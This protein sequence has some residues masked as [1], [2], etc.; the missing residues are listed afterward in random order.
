M[1]VR[2]CPARPGPKLQAACCTAVPPRLLPLHGQ[3]P[4]AH[5]LHL[6]SPPPALCQDELAVRRC[7]AEFRQQHPRYIHLLQACAASAAAASAAARGCHPQLQAWAA[8][9]AAGCANRQARA[10]A[11]LS[12]DNASHRWPCSFPLYPS[13][14]CTPSGRAKGW[15]SRSLGRPPAARGG[16]GASQDW[17]PICVAAAAWLAAPGR[18]SLLSACP[19]RAP[20]CR[21]RLAAAAAP[22][23]AGRQGGAAAVPGG[24]ERAQ[25]GAPAASLLHA[26]TAP[27]GCVRCGLTPGPVGCGPRVAL[28]V[29]LP[30][31]PRPSRQSL[32]APSHCPQPRAVP[33]AWLYR[34]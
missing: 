9:A 6:A 2:A 26:G 17:V 21:R 27:C 34:L 18:C 22:G 14:R 4:P 24:I 8:S 28:S 23:A 10:A 11:A 19:S 5:P 25:V 30:S 7:A 29:P 1:R 31:P 33:A 15:V 32:A 12:S 16:G 3:A 13:L 20:A